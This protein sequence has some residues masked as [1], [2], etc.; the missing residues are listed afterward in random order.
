MQECPKCSS[1]YGDDL[2]ICRTCG[3]I[4]TAATSD[5]PQQPA[6]NDPPPHEA[7]EALQTASTEKKSW[8]CPRCGQSVPRDFEVCWNCGTSHD[9]VPNPDFSKEPSSGDNDHPCEEET[10]EQAAAANQPARQC[11]KCGSSKVIPN[12]RILDPSP[13]SAG[14]LQVVVDGDPDALSF[15]DR[16]FD[17]VT[18]DICGDCGHV[19]LKAEHPGELYK[20]YLQSRGPQGD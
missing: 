5:L 20:H 17:R 3:A 14:K 15:K 16:L 1:R 7:E 13:Y 11:P 2:K 12:T 6:N 8:T 18:A 9:G 10:P 19:E 4:L